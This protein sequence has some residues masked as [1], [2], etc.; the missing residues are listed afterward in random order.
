MLATAAP[1]P[2]DERS[3]AFEVKWDGYRGV[4][5]HARE[6]DLRIRSRNLLDVTRDYPELQELRGLLAGHDVVLDGEIVAFDEDGRASFAAMQEGVEGTRAYVAFDLLFLDG[7]DT[8]G[9]PYET[10]RELLEGL[11]LASAHVQVSPSVVGS[12]KALLE[13]PGIEGIVAK[14]LGS[15]YVKSRRSESWIKI[16]LLRRQEFVVGGWLRGNGARASTLGS[17]LL[18]VHDAPGEGPLRYAGN[19]GTGFTDEAL[20]ELR[21]RLQPHA[22]RA[23]PFDAPVPRPRDV[24][25]VDPVLVCE[26]EFAEWTR[27]GHLRHPSFQGLRFDKDPRDVVRE[28]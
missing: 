15:A 28:D 11:G 20:G 4:V 19:V 26:V 25:F 7:V 21:A 1:Y 22:R 18:G 10:R 27:D 8:T 17:L 5:H 23:S 6:G 2:R 16:K 3:Y 9:L 14:R 12:G 24:V 13:T